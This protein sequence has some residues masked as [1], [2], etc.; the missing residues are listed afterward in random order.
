MILVMEHA[1]DIELLRNYSIDGS[2]EAFAALVQRHVNLVY[3]TAR[4][5]VPDDTMAEEVTQATFIVLARKA[6]SLN[7]KT[8]L[9]AWLYRTARFAAADARKIQIRRTK[10]EQEVA[11]MESSQADTTWQEIE[12]LLDDAMNSLGEADRAALLLRY[13]ENK[14]LR[15]VG[16][17]LGVSDDTAQKRITRALDRLRKTFSQDGVALTVAALAATLP[18]RAVESAPRALAQSAAHASISSATISATTTLL[19]KGTLQMIL[20]SKWKFALGLAVLLILAA[21][22][23]TVLTQRKTPAVAAAPAAPAVEDRTTP[24]GALR[25][26]AI[27]LEN[28]DATNVAAC[29]YAQ[30]PTQERFMAAM[31]GVVRSEGAMRRAMEKQ[32]G[33]NGSA[34]LPKRPMFA[35]SFGQDNLDAAEFEVQGTNA[36]VRTPGRADRSDEMRLVQVGGVWKVGGDKGDSPQAIKGVESMERMSSSIDSFT[37]A[38]TS[39]EFP[40]AEEA[41]RAMRTRVGSALRA[42][43]NQ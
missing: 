23:A 15:E 26:L 25:F 34:A 22:T 28:F 8:I 13:F 37:A 40:T 31:V 14:S 5:Q 29:L 38:I 11:R 12:P 7:D 19:V 6:R 3:S 17:A 43:S 33:T 20:W 16:A 41:L 36:L 4:R 18:A 24:L 1:T 27:A 21:G 35:M 32:F 2:E 39:G 9:P 30:S 10:Y 42:K